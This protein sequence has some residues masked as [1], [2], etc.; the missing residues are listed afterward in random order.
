[1]RMMLQWA[2]VLN[3][4]YV[5]LAHYPHN[6]YMARIADEMGLLLWAEVPVYWTIH[7]DDPATLANARNQLTELITRDR[8]RASVVIWSMANE[9]P[10]S[11]PR[12]RALQTAACAGVGY[13]PSL[14]PRS[15]VHR[16]GVPWRRAAGTGPAPPG[17]SSGARARG[18]RG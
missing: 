13:A 5:R 8:N 4:N 11:A 10:V 15:R 17:C 1:M 9:T 16:P 12:T 18:R 3:C 7:W 14:R 2:K 6:D